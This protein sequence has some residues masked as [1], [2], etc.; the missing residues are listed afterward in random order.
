MR[1]LGA[2]CC[3]TLWFLPGGIPAAHAAAPENAYDVV[4]ETPSKDSSGSMPLGNGSTGLNAWINPAGELEFYISRT[5]S[6]GDNARLLKVGKVRVAL[7]PAP[8]TEPFEQTLSLKDATMVVRYGKGSD[9]V[10]L[11][12]WADANQPVIH[13]TVDSPQPVKATAAI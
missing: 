9:A 3:L 12:L 8:P 6:W 2:I 13:V 4:W 11:R 7:D 1:M 5:D 10:T